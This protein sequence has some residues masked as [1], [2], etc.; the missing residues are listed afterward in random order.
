[1]GARRSV[2]HV[3]VGVVLDNQGRVLI[4]RRA[5][6]THQGGLWEFPGGK[7]EPGESVSGALRRELAEELGIE[8]GRVEPWLRVPHD[9]GD[10]RV[11]LDVHRVHGFHGTARGLENQPIRWVPVAQLRDYAFPVA[12]RPI[13]TAL[14]LPPVCLITPTLTS[15]PAFLAGIRGAVQAGTRFLQ[16]RRHDLPPPDFLNLARRV[17]ALC[18]EAGAILA[19]NTRPDL[20]LELGAEACHLSARAALDCPPGRRPVP[21]DIWLGVS[22]H[23]A[24]EIDRAAGL[25]ADYVFVSPVLPTASHGGVSPLGWAGL[26]QLI[27]DVPMPVY[28]LG[29]VGPADLAQARR[30]GAHGVAGIR[31]MWPAGCG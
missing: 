10:K 9:Y 28:A 22:C 24:R 30:H 12:N 2:V 17:A 25:D 1:M 29:G 23:D 8:I 27:A 14:S 19:V 4:S 6:D 11:L 31:A 18:R 13:M 20:A 5:R 21:R 7:V 26:E 16:L 3:A 15:E